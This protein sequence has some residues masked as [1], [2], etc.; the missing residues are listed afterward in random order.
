GG[1]GWGWWFVLLAVFAFATAIGPALPVRGWLYDSVPPTRYFRHS[2]LFRGY[3]LFAIAVLAGLACR[4]LAGMLRRPT[5]GVV[6][7]RD[8]ARR[9]QMA[10]VFTGMG[11]VGAAVLAYRL[12]EGRW[13]AAD[14]RPDQGLASI[15]LLTFS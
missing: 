13:A 9:M 14:P 10:L 15:H 11:T 6:P 8:G 12:L 2:S 5:D 7:G 4:D 1:P 3:T